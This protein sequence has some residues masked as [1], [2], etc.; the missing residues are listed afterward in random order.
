MYR[1]H[2]KHWWAGYNA[3]YKIVKRGEEIKAKAEKRAAEREHH[4]ETPKKKR[5]HC[6]VL[7]SPTFTSPIHVG[8]HSCVRSGNSKLTLCLTSDD[9]DVCVRR[10]S[11]GVENLK[12]SK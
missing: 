3:A 9:M 8:I 10:C 2:T 6:F 1:S 11:T 12:E 7:T 5:G 4:D